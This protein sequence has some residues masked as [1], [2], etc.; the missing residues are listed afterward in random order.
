MMV[1]LTDSQSAGE[2][3]Y[4]MDELHFSGGI[5]LVT[6]AVSSFTRFFFFLT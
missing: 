5:G 2:L 6:E 1:N 3:S 4:K